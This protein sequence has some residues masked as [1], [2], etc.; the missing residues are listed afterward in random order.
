MLTRLLFDT[1]GP[2]ADN[3]HVIGSLVITFAIMALAEVARPLRWVNGAFGAWLLLSPW[4]LDG[5]SLAGGVFT[6]VSGLSLM[7][8][9]RPR[10]A[11]LSHYGAWDR[12]LMEKGVPHGQRP[13]AG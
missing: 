13:T 1:S 10:G 7:A 4:L 3:D 11:I 8:L 9:C 5:H 2:A 6:G 12:Y